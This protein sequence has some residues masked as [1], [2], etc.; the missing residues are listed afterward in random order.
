MKCRGKINVKGKGSMV[1]YF[2]HKKNDDEE[3][4][5]HQ[6]SQIST[7]TA[8]GSEDYDPPEDLDNMNA[9][10]ARLTQKRKSLCRQHHIFSSLNNNKSNVSINSDDSTDTVDPNGPLDFQPTEKTNLI[11]DSRKNITG[12]SVISPESN[13]KILRNDFRPIIPLH[14]NTLMDS[15]ESLQKLL[16]NDMTFSDITGKNPNKISMESND[17]M[18]CISSRVMNN[19]ANDISKMNGDDDESVTSP[20]LSNAAE[21]DNSDAI[22][23]DSEQ[24]DT[25]ATSNLLKISKSW[26]PMGREPFSVAKMSASKSMCAISTRNQNSAPIYQL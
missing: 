14:C 5:P 18:N 13:S 24:N 6:I 17:T 19:L 3:G 23:S 22:Q 7:A 1:T 12:S 26:Y 20:L 2:L 10:S 8:A 4:L 15:I 21:C 9:E 11:S 25:G 16:K